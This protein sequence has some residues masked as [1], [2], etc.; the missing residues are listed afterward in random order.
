MFF[1]VPHKRHSKFLAARILL[2][3]N[4]RKAMNLVILEKQLYHG[5]EISSVKLPAQAIFH[6]VCYTNE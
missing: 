3:L 4:Y 6:A 2:S 5:A 1:S